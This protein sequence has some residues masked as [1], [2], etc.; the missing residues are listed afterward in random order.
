MIKVIITGA[1]SGAIYSLIASGLVLTYSATGVFNLGYGAVAFVA[2]FLFYEL[3]TGLGW[4][5]FLA[6]L[7]VVLVFAPLLGML[8]DVVLFRPLAK[9]SEAA[10]I[11]CTVGLLVALPAL[12]LWIVERGIDMFD[13]GI[14]RGND[15]FLTPGVFFQPTKVWEIGGITVD[16]NQ[17]LVLATAAGCAIALGLFSRTAL[18]LRMRAVVDRSELASLRGVNEASTLRTATVVGTV[19]AALAGVVGA[20]ILNSLDAIPY[21]TAVF[22]ASTAAVIGG[23]R[24]VPKAF[25]G[26]LILGVLMSL[27]FRYVEIEGVRQINNAVPFVLLLAGLLILAKSRGRVAGTSNLEPPP[28][29]WNAD[30]PWWRQR[31]AW[32]AA[33]CLLIVWMLVVLDDFWRAL[34]LRGLAFS[35]ILLSL[36]IVTGHGG[37]VSLAQATFATGA[38]LTTGMLMNRFDWPIALAVIGGVAAAA[39][40]GVLVALPALRLGGLAFTLAT[41]ALAF[42]GGTV[43]FDWTTLSGGDVGWR[44]TRPEIGPIDFGSD[45]T[46]G[47]VLIFAIVVVVLLIGNLDQSPTGRAIA[48]VRVAEPAASSIGL[49]PVQSKLRL[50]VLSAVIAGIGGVTLAFVD[51]G[52]TKTTTN[53]VTGLMWLTVVVLLGVRRRGA[54]VIGGLLLI[55]FPQLLSGGFQL[56]FGIAT[57]SGTRSVEVPAILFGLGA[58]S[59]ARAPDGALSDMARKRHLKRQR[60]AE[61]R[62]ERAPVESAEEVST[63]VARPAPSAQSAA[64][65][66]AVSHAPPNSDSL[67]ALR[68]LRGGYGPV[69]VLHGVDLDVE[70]GAITALL[71][72][73]GAGKSSLC[74]A[75]AGLMPIQGV[76]LFDGRE[77][78]SKS[79]DWRAREGMLYAPESRGIFP[80]LS[81]EDNLRLVTTSASDRSKAYDRFPI[82]HERRRLPA[83]MLSGGEQQMLAIAPLLVNPPRLLI[84]DEPTLG[85]APLVVDS[86]LQ[87]LVELRSNGTGILI[88]EEKPRTVLAL[89]DYVALIELGRVFWRGAVNE[90]TDELVERAYHLESTP[91][92]ARGSNLPTTVASDNGSRP[93]VIAGGGD[94]T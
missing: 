77:V 86:V 5:R 9:A 11:V 25:A 31:L 63:G 58:A 14:P 93:R 94:A 79:A 41:L 23:L 91:N 85:L 69:E 15:V 13:W 92:D 22:V 52:V 80:G 82:L 1:V 45:A 37:L 21:A 60:R 55:V 90:L 66:G 33:T 12:T 48:A 3:N 46:F 51:G 67:L 19:L 8:L 29:D 2:A 49:S 42:L 62:Q 74:R 57:W 64:V 7:F 16:S 65:E 36:T 88:A 27:T 61:R 70:A 34:F 87:L 17:V 28:I 6:A 89:A 53:P 26:G 35:L 59:L 68:Q 18:G 44:F 24:S 84:I 47:V 76:V 38:A 39:V 4:D 83:A 56:P 50:F 40:L 10:K 71:G 73:N 30:M 43:L 72:A 32:V 54:A 20:P 81:V 75:A 78:T